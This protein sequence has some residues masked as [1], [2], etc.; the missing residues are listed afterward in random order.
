MDVKNGGVWFFRWN[1]LYHDFGKTKPSNIKR[2]C[3]YNGHGKRDFN[4]SDGVMVKTKISRPKKL[5]ELGLLKE[6]IRV[7]DVMINGGI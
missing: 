4:D 1:R 6:A 3:N 2:I 5:N 7:V